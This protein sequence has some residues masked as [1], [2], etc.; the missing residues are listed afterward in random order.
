MYTQENIE[1]L[2]F[3]STRQIVNILEIVRIV[4][5][6]LEEMDRLLHSTGKTLGG[7][8]QSLTRICQILKGVQRR[9]CLPNFVADFL[10]E[11]RVSV[12]NIGRLLENIQSTNRFLNQ[13]LEHTFGPLGGEWSLNPLRTTEMKNTMKTLGCTVLDFS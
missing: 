3:G 6:T 12:D 4:R 11:T 2:L 5:V 8:H 7:P 10:A 1:R 9:Q 13:L